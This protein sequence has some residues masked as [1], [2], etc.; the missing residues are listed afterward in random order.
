MNKYWRIKLVINIQSC[1]RGRG[2][3]QCEDVYP[4]NHA[5]RTIEILQLPF[6]LVSLAFW[7]FLASMVFWDNFVSSSCLCTLWNTCFK[8]SLI[9]WQDVFLI[10]VCVILAP[11]LASASA[12]SFPA[13]CQ[14]PTIHCNARQIHLLVV[15][16]GQRSRRLSDLQIWH[17]DLTN[18][19]VH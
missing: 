19:L 8:C 5:Q 9:E 16:P 14:C 1:S 2:G 6:F 12:C 13:I 10:C 17:S 7:L 11:F 15:H 18:Q 3:F 4:S